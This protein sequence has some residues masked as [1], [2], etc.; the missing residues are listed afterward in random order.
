MLPPSW[1]QRPVPI[2]SRSVSPWTFG[3][4]LP[5]DSWLHHG[6]FTTAEG[7]SFTEQACQRTS[8]VNL[9]PVTQRAIRYIV[10]T[11][12]VCGLAYPGAACAR[13]TPAPKLILHEEERVVKVGSPVRDFFAG[14]S[15]AEGDYCEVTGIGKDLTNS[16]P[17]D[18]V[19]FS[20]EEPVGCSEGTRFLSGSIIGIALT[21]TG[22]I[23][24]LS[25]WVL[26]LPGPCVYDVDR[27]EADDPIPGELL[28]D[29]LYGTAT[30]RARRSA[31][32][33][34][35]KK[36]VFSGADVSDVE[37]FSIPYSTELS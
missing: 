35:A 24:E 25:D 18:L 12:A 33:C 28:R 5:R 26:E 23:I 21:D 10:T 32:T 4:P 15:T 9:K 7:N 2:K 16:L 20:G 13:A 8:E 30:L 37:S 36:S 31:A 22:Q 6:G 34:A 17:V 1:T 3:F 14:V 27:L 11:L 29:T 19:A